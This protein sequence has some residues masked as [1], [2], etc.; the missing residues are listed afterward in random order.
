MGGGKD[1]A[2][3]SSTVKGQGKAVMGVQKGVPETEVQLTLAFLGAGLLAC[4]VIPGLLVIW[5][6]LRDHMEAEKTAK[7]SELETGGNPPF[8]IYG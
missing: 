5:D 7:K 3:G 2:E 8:S 4:V 1:G 6:R